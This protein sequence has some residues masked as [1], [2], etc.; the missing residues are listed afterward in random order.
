MF[1]EASRYYLAAGIQN[2]T[3]FDYP[4]ATAFGGAGE[5]ETLE[6][7]RRGEI[8]QVVVGTRHPE[9]KLNPT[10]LLDFVET[11]MEEAGTRGPFRLYL[12]AGGSGPGAA[13]VRE[14]AGRG[15]P[16]AAMPVTAGPD[17]RP[18]EP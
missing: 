12:L 15:E 11:G 10:L 14:P 8:E 18:G 1:P 16:R 13:V 5:R 7:I 4:L 3:P 2:P 6:R 9:T 17:P